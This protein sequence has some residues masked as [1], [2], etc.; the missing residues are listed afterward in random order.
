MKLFADAGL[1]GYNSSANSMGVWLASSLFIDIQG[2]LI[3]VHVHGAV[4][5]LWCLLGK[6]LQ[7]LR[8]ARVAACS[9]FG[10]TDA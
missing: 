4:A 3:C 5:L 1:N 7:L 6:V 2:F 8:A 10:R 9:S